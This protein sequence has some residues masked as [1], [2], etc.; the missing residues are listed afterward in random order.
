MTRYVNLGGVPMNAFDLVRPSGGLRRR[1]S[2][3]LLFWNPLICTLFSALFPSRGHW[4][5]DWSTSLVISTT[6]TL[7]CFWGTQLIRVLEAWLL[8]RGGRPV[9][10]HHQGWYIALSILIMIPG[11]AV[12]YRAGAIYRTLLGMPWDRMPD[13]E[14]YKLGAVWGTAIATLMFL[15]ETRRDAR[16]AAAEARKQALQAQVS[17][18]TAQMNPHLLFNALNTVASMIPTDPA[19]AEETL[20]RLSELYRGVL[21]SSKRNS[22]SLETELEI[23]EAYLAVEKARFGERLAV[24]KELDASVTPARVVIPALLLQPLVEN[25]IKHGLTPKIAGGTVSLAITREGQDLSLVVEDDG[26]GYQP[27][28]RPSLGSGSA[29]ENCRERLRLMYGDRAR[30]TIGDTPGGGTRVRM[31]IPEGAM[32]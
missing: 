28:A 20:V 2:Q 9:P 14:A 22:H 24:R 29:L 5:L 31:T 19:A 12:G 32:T 23:C 4:L 26:V 8:R 18:L 6:I 17:A 27:G 7:L 25:A 15:W 11:L 1:I 3:A 30:L 16:L 21:A 10:I 13:F